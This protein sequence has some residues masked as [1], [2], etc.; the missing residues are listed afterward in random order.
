MPTVKFDLIAID[1]VARLPDMF[2]Q[3]FTA[4]NNMP[5]SYLLKKETIVNY[6]NRAL[7]KVFFDLYISASADINKFTKIVPELTKLS[8]D[9][10]FVNGEYTLGPNFYDLFK[11][12]S[13]TV[14]GKYAK[15]KDENKYMLYLTGEYPEYVATANEPILIQVG[16]KLTVFPKTTS[17]VNLHYIGKPIDPSTGGYLT[18]N[19]NYDSPFGYHWNE[20]IADSAYQMYLTETLQT[21]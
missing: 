9:I 11:V 4:G 14:N 20:V 5:D 3:P 16:S 15:I 2:V 13:A 18:Q 17:T 8:G 1:F 10:S 7:N 19:G 6:I 21:T 12:I